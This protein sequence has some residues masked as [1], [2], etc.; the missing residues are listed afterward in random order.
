MHSGM[1][2]LLSVLDDNFSTSTLVFDLHQHL[3]PQEFTCCCGSFVVNRTKRPGNEVMA[4]SG[5]LY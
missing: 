5:Q 1:M 4:L 2:S 3:V